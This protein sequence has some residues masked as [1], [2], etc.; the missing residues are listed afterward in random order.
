VEYLFLEGAET[1]TWPR[2]LVR[3]E[4]NASSLVI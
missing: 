1:V 2:T 4:Q 3:M